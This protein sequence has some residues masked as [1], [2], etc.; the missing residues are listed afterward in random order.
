MSHFDISHS[1][2]LAPQ[3]RVRISLRQAL[4]LYRSR[5]D[6]AHL[7]PSQLQDIGLNPLDAR[8]EANRAPWDVPQNWLK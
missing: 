1:P 3:P 8:K 6:L 2:A 5:R 4:A 7:D